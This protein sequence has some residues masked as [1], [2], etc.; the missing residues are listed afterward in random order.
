MNANE[1]YINRFGAIRTVQDL[2]DA[3]E[4]AL[5]WHEI[6]QRDF[7]RAERTLFRVV[8]DAFDLPSM[9]NAC[10]W[11]DGAAQDRLLAQM[12]ALGELIHT[13]DAEPDA[14]EVDNEILLFQ[15]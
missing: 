1:K 7:T 12:A 9:R 4:V 11:L 6:V 13:A 2:T 15:E 10:R 8:L 14:D 5:T 3:V